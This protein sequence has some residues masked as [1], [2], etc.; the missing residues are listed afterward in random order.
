M[1]DALRRSAGTWV[2]RIFLMV[3]VASFAVWGIGDIFRTDS[4]GGVINVGDHEISAAEVSM[5][6]NRDLR[7]LQTQLGTQIDSQQAREM[8]L[9]QSTVQQIVARGLLDAA[10]HDLGLGIPDARL[11]KEVREN[12]AFRDEFGRFDRF[13]FERLLRENG[14]SEQG[15]LDATRRDLV[16][17]QLFDSLTVGLTTP[18]VLVDA[19]YGFQQERRV[20]EV[21]RVPDTALATVAPPD[22]ATLA[23]YHQS[24]AARYTAPEYRTISFFTLSASDLADEVNVTEEELREAYQDRLDQFTTEARREVEQVLVDDEATAQQVADRVA[25]GED[26]AT[27]AKEVAGIDSDGLALG[28]VTPDSLPLPQ[29]TVDT[30]FALPEGGTSAPVKTDLGWHVFRVVK[31]LSTAAT[32]SFEEV[33]DA[34]DEQLRLDRAAELMFDTADK[35]ED[36]FAAGETVEEVAQRFGL[37]L[38]KVPEVDGDGK[39]RAGNPVPELPAD[40]AFLET[41][42][43]EQPGDEPRLFEADSGSYF[44]VRVDRIIDPA[45]RPLAEVRDKVAADWTAEQRGEMAA[46]RLEEL[47]EKARAGTD[48]AT[49]ATE[50]G[51]EVSTSEPLL[52]TAFLRE[53]KLGEAVV[54]NLFTAQVGQVVAGPNADG[55]GRVI[56]RL[57]EIKPAAPDADPEAKERIAELVQQAYVQDIRTQFQAALAQD[58]EVTINQPAIDALF[59][60]SGR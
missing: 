43:A 53:A 60:Q 41:A 26:Y 36:G 35:I 10:A 16:R 51:G 8:G 48:L 6:F 37:T 28:V 49:L 19:Y 1:L 29:D 14:F 11:A 27:V 7:R 46:R 13:R 22:E 52:R 45:V 24:H 25:A 32:Q 4:G 54:R 50:T 17:L 18:K 55:D 31:V 42:F 33:R 30:I 21:L 5:T 40:P 2:V 44:L 3:L 34:L 23:A 9:V 58:Y 20:A 59:D 47:A 57:V 15:Y 56:A 38:V 12:P 39:D